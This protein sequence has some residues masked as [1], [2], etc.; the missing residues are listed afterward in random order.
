MR[1]IILGLCALIIALTAHNL[2][3][4]ED[5]K[6]VFRGQKYDYKVMETFSKQIQELR[7]NEE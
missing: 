6:E 7:Q 4:Q 5:L 2:Y 3:L 1:F